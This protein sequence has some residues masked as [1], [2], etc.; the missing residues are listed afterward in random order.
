AAGQ[1]TEFSVG[2]PRGVGVDVG[3]VAAGA[4]GSVWFTEF[5]PDPL[6]GSVTPAGHVTRFRAGLLAGNNSEPGDMTRGT[7]GNVYFVD[8]NSWGRAIGRVTPRG[9]ITEFPVT[10]SGDSSDFINSIAPGPGGIW[11]IEG[12]VRRLSL[13]G[14]PGARPLQAHL[15]CT[16][17]GSARADWV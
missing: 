14:A 11:M 2:G 9:Q 5:F 16:H 4:G 15:S 12:A 3:G 17:H 10:P 8:N 1:I 7:D 13:G 6:V